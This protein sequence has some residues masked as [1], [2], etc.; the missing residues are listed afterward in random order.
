M[1]IDPNHLGPSLRVLAS[2]SSGNCSVLRFH[3]DGWPRAILID[4]GLSPKRAKPL[5]RDSAITVEQIDTILLTHL[6]SDHFHHSWAK[7]LPERVKL[8]VHRQHEAQA[9]RL[10]P[11]RR[12]RVMDDHETLAPGLSLRCFRLAHDREGVTAFRFELQAHRASLGFA[13]DLGRVTD[14]LLHALRGVDV[15]AIESNYCPEL[16]LASARPAFLKRRIM[17]GAGHLSNY[18]ALAAVEAIAPTHHVVLLH[19]SQQCNRPDVVA[20]LH[21]GSDYALTIAEQHRPTR[22]I[23][24]PPPAAWPVQV[25]AHVATPPRP[26]ADAT[27]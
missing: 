25:A 15:L 12:L 1:S 22:W 5:L 24:I 17:G 11:R 9:A 23:S 7:V 27:S 16:Q 20:A 18:E 8:A 3:A 6:D 2:G 14:D 21:G 10:I 26:V 13:T 4:A 19:L